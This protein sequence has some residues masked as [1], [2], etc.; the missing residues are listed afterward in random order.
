MR[1]LS[2][3]IG[4]I[5]GLTWSTVWI[6]IAIKSHIVEGQYENHTDDP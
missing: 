5:N 3:P 1:L 4:R 2:I 6:I